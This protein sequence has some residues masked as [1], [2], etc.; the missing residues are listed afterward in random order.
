MS[1][2]VVKPKRNEVLQCVARYSELTPVTTGLPDMH[3]EQCKRTFLSVLG[4]EQP[5]GE[6]QHSPFGNHVS[7]RITSQPTGFG[8]AFVRSRPGCG[9]LMH[10]HD[11]SESFMPIEGRWMVQWEGAD[12]IDQVILDPM[13]FI[14]VP[15]GV[16]RRFECVEAPAGKDEGILFA[17][18]SG[19]APA[20]EW[21]PEAVKLMTDSG[22]SV[23]RAAG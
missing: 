22:A 15:I 9:V 11:T 14:A 12:G 17:I 6:V 1:I 20:V 23:V 7:P 3:L 16:Q 21:S 5:R 4:F 19:E 8:A 10:A 13:D 2:P 18:I